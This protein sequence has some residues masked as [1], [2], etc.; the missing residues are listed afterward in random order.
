MKK[1]LVSY[2]YNR[3][4]AI[5]FL[6]LVAVVNDSKPVEAAELEKYVKMRGKKKCSVKVGM[7]KTHIEM[8]NKIYVRI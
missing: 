8:E 3:Y 7:Y 6:Q 2:N 4:V 1:Y 5:S